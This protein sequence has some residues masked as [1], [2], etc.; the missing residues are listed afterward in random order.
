MVTASGARLVIRG[1]A[2]E[3]NGLDQEAWFLSQAR[4]AGVPVPEVV[5]FGAVETAT[6]PRTVMVQT[7]VTGRELRVRRQCRPA[8]VRRGHDNARMPGIAARRS[9]VGVGR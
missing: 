5:W 2:V 7:A 3:S 4:Q 8:G 9:G 1:E 6:G